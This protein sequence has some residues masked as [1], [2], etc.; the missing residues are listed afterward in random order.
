MALADTEDGLTAM[1]IGMNNTGALVV[2]A[3]LATIEDRSG[4][5]R[6][7]TRGKFVAIHVFLII[8]GGCLQSVTSLNPDLPIRV[9]QPFW[10][11]TAEPGRYRL[12]AP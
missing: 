12:A 11:R 2:L 8:A 4:H 10:L 3:L 5:F 7:F 6:F 1:I 9:I